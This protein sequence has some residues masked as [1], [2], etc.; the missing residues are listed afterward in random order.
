MERTR[1]WLI[2]TLAGGLLARCA[3]RAAAGEAWTE[4]RATGPL[5]CHAQFPLGE[6]A[7]L[8]AR[9]GE[10]QQELCQRLAVPPAREPV[11]VYLF[12]S[13]SE[14][15]EFV[16]PRHP[17]LITRPAG[18]VKSGGIGQVMAYRGANFEIDLRHECTH[19]LLH[20]ALP[21][22]PLWL[23][24]G[25]AEYFELPPERR[26]ASPHRQAVLWQSRL[27]MPLPL[28][29]I[30]ELSSMADMGRGQYRWSWAW[31]CFLLDGPPE[32]RAVLARYVQGLRNG[33]APRISEVL[34]QELPDPE[35][36]LV[37][38]FKHA[39]P[40]PLAVRPASYP[41]PTTTGIQPGPLK[42]KAHDS[43]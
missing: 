25:L 1:R 23:D 38:F 11:F 33:A 34:A 36:Q 30:E 24:E 32:A 29:R 42:S 4:I 19:A 5:V 26:E 28:A 31:T 41:S 8:F 12:D 3:P 2:A 35:R 7:E 14:Y 18:Y 20:A 39:K 9:L 15:R 10:L 13:R 43:R 37:E 16:G 40:P 17:E 27:G 22:V 6:H 21:R